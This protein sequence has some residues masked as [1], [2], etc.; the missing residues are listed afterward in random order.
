M[1]S[2]ASSIAPCGTPAP[3]RQSTLGSSYGAA[4]NPFAP[5]AD[6][7]ALKDKAQGRGGWAIVDYESAARRGEPFR[8][9]I[10][11]GNCAIGGFTTKRICTASLK[12]APTDKFLQDKGIDESIRVVGF[13]YDEPE[14][15]AKAKDRGDDFRSP[16]HEWKIGREEV[17]AFWRKMPFDLCLPAVNGQTA[18]GNCTLCFLKGRKKIARL[19]NECP[20]RAD[21]WIEMETMMAQRRNRYGCRM[22]LTRMLDGK[23]ANAAETGWAL[24]AGGDAKVDSDWI[25]DGRIYRPTFLQGTDYRTIKIAAENGTYREWK[26]SDGSGRRTFWADIDMPPPPCECGD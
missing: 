26:G 12:L 14:R 24:R 15:V 2:A 23:P 5:A 9:L 4:D 21:R 16:L 11:S 8:D 10:L 13:R 18:H 25:S 17:V 1:K 20:Q 6:V 19:M 3:V 22:W 7:L